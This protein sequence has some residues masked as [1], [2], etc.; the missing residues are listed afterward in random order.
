MLDDGRSERVVAEFFNVGK[1]T[2]SRIKSNRVAI[3]LH[4][5]KTGETHENIKKRKH[6]V[7]VPIYEDIETTVIEFLK[8]AREIEECL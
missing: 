2:I 6:A 3:Q 1:G 4:V 7:V 8:L 5:D